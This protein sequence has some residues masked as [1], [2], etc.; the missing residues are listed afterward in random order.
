M[1]IVRRCAVRITRTGPIRSHYLRRALTSLGSHNCIQC[2]RRRGSLEL[3]VRRLGS[4]VGRGSIW[5]GVRRLQRRLWGTTGVVWILRT[6]LL[7]GIDRRTRGLCGRSRLGS[8][9]VVI[10]YRAQIHRDGKGSP[11]PPAR[12]DLYRGARATGDRDIQTEELYKS[13]VDD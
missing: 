3:L 8:A 13:R 9:G 10:H 4:T 7:S 2:W 5:R 1:R 11:R 6:L 12:A